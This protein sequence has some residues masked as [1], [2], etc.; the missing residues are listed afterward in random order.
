MEFR[1]LG[2]LEVVGED[3]PLKLGGPKQLALLAHLI[4]RPNRVVPVSVLIDELWGEEPPDTARNTL[5]TYVYRLRKLLGDA[6]IEARSGGY[7]LHAES[8]EVDAARFEALIT[9]AKAL[10]ATDPAAAAG[11]LDEGLGLWRGGALA[12]LADEPSLR[13]EI[14]RLDELRLAATEHRISAQLA[15]GRHSTMVSELEA[16]TARYPL[17]E[18]LW[19]HLMIAL[20]RGGRQAEALDAY[21]RARQ[22]LAD[23]LGADPSAELQRLHQQILDRDPDLRRPT[24]PEP[25]QSVRPSRGDLPLGTEFAGYRIEAVLGRGGMSVVY[26]AEHLGLGRKV[27]LKLLAPQLGVDDRF[28]ERFVRESRIA[29]GME[30][31][32]IVPIYEAGEAEG[33]LFIAMRYVPGTDLGRLIRREGTLDPGRTLWIVRQTASALDAAHARGLVHRDVKPGNILVVPGEGS[34]GRDLVYLSDFGL[35]KR[36]E[37]GTGDITQTGQFV[38]TVDYVA[39]EQIEGKRID[40]RVDVYALGCVVFECL[41]GHVPYERDTQVAALYA[42]LGEKPPRL[43]VSRPDLPATIDPVVAK[44]LSKTA[45]GRYPTCGEFAMAVR[46]TLG[47]LAGE[48]TRA[49]GRSGWSQWQAGAVALVAALIAGIIV[50]WVSRGETPAAV[51]ATSAPPP[52]ASLSPAPEPNFRTVERPLTADEERLLTSI[53]EDVGG[54]CL[55]LDRAEPV[56][57]ELAALVCTTDELEVL[58][59]LFPNRDLMDEAFQSNANIT[60]A[61]AGECATDHLAVTPYTIGGEPAGQVLC[62]TRAIDVNAGQAGGPKIRTSHI[63]WTDENSAIYAHAIRTDLGDLTLYE[64]W[65]SSSGPVTSTEPGGAMAKDRPAAAA[66]RRP[67]EGSYLVSVDEP[68][69]RVG[70]VDLVG[71]NGGSLVT[72]RIHIEAGGYELG[73]NGVIVDSGEILFQKPNLVVFNPISGHCARQGIVDPASY[74]WSASGTSLTWKVTE[75]GTCAGPDQVP[76]RIAWTRAPSGVIAFSSQGEIFLMDAAGFNLE[77]LTGDAETGPNLSPTWSPDGTKIAFAGG[78]PDGFDLYGMNANGSGLERITFEAGDEIHP[79][80]SPDGNRIAFV[81]DDPAVEPFRT[82][83]VVVDPDGG[84]W[85]DLVTR[86]NERVGWP[87]WS[88]DGRRIAFV[89]FRDG[90]NIYVMRADGSDVTKVHEEPIGLLGLPLAWTPDGERIVFWSEAIGR[91]RLLSMRP[92]GS[93]VRGFVDRFPSSPYIGDLAPDWSPD[94]RWIVMA[95]PWVPDDMVGTLVLLMR[96]DGSEVFTV[97]YYV[98]EPSWRPSGAD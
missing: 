2:P 52:T 36:L 95:G 28:R 66:N 13:G 31:P 45:D 20:Y 86:V 57:G 35:T 54:D 51:G 71:A 37:G 24:G 98:T 64:W 47:P 81:V 96:A 16:L 19:A 91:R 50:F 88:P 15:A 18:R 12:N 63:E 56:Q 48:P 79:A 4:L 43:T 14:A 44:A 77:P 74:E 84:G 41:T 11:E 26:L 5:Q 21:Q 23:E 25:P 73:R 75:G 90:F 94:G 32:N 82:S 69:E 55:P 72:Y 65:L 3:G 97:G 7:V 58:Y 40:A 22:V 85:T 29:A 62:Y 30:H 6:R 68:F 92:D 1:I 17:R 27:A 60:R 89:G 42:H 80:F 83:I 67:P 9:H 78:G 8:A 70:E 87:A 39:P 33:L 38:G 46:G 53:P 93:D 49:V 59:E 34:E 10:I 76:G 61:P